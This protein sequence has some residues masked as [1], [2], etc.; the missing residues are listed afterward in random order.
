MKIKTLEV[1][2]CIYTNVEVPDRQT[3]INAM[4]QNKVI[5][6]RDGNKKIYI[7]GSF[8]VSFEGVDY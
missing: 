6:I 5:A 8:I 4:E 2:G 3:L 7:N 1:A